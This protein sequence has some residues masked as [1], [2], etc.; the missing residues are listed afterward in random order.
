[1][2][3]SLPHQTAPSYCNDEDI[4]VRAGGDF[5]TL[6]PPWQLMAAGADGVFAAGSRWVLT[7]ASVNFQNNA[8]SPNQVVQLTHPKSQYQ[9]GGQFLAIDSVQDNTITLRRPYKANGVGQ[10]PAPAVGLTGVSFTIA[11]LDPQIA[12][13]SFDLKQRFGI[14]ELVAPRTS[15]WIYDLQVLRKAAAFTVLYDRYVS[16]NRS[17]TGDF[18]WKLGHIRNQREEA[19][20]QLQVRWG[21]FGN[22]SEPATIFGCKLTR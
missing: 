7:S 16:E 22:S 17:A 13:A 8:V 21:P 15:T 6:V 1:M 12:E 20:A 9:G 4:L 5:A 10:P 11:T 19:I 18:Q 3:T 2:T 14:D